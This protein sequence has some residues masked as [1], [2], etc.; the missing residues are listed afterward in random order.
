LL[1]ESSVYSAWH[2]RPWR[3]VTR[4]TGGIQVL[5]YCVALTLIILAGCSPVREVARNEAVGVKKWSFRTGGVVDS[6]AAF[7]KD[8]AIYLASMDSKVYALDTA[9]GRKNWEFHTNGPVFSSCAVDA[10]NTVY[11]VSTGGTLYALDG[12][13]GQR[14]WSSRI[15]IKPLSSPTVAGDSVYAPS[16][17][18]MLYC[19]DKA[20]KLRWLFTTKGAIESE[21]AVG[22][23]GTVYLGSRDHNIYALEAH[24]GRE[25]WTVSTPY[26]IT[27][28]PVVSKDGVVLVASSQSLYALDAASGSKK[29]IFQGDFAGSSPALDES[30]HRLY[31]GSADGTVH[32]LDA[33]DGSRIWEFK[34]EGWI[35]SPP[36]VTRSGTVYVSAGLTLY[37]L[38]ASTGCLKWRFHTTGAW[39]RFTLDERFG[40]SAPVVGM[41][42]TVYVGSADKNIYAIR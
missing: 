18:G 29:W 15:G 11:A 31:I 23:N 10:D 26:P 25:K 19:F 32:A 42:G 1:Q 40:Y 9:T 14:K 38:H 17:N 20:G 6:T 3:A 2:K 16:D 21:C 12:Y 4:F 27:G 30:S 24:T 41:D 8:S 22:P 7:G 28:T 39:N 36:A 37:A 33:R 34:A 5:R 13:T 35:V